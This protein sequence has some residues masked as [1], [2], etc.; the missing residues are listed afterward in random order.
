MKKKTRGRVKRLGDA[1]TPT[2]TTVTTMALALLAPLVHDAFCLSPSHPY[3]RLSVHT[4][5]SQCSSV[6]RSVGRLTRVYENRIGRAAEQMPVCLCVCGCR[7]EVGRRRGT[8]SRTSHTHTH[9]HTRERGGGGGWKR[10][11]MRAP[12]FFFFFFFHA[13]YSKGFAH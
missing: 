3:V 8:S 10:E 5:Q 1:S 12:S 2:T 4:P 6:G 9:T 13:A 11:K 7:K